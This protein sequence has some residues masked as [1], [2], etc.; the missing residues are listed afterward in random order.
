MKDMAALS[1][2]KIFQ[3]L[4][5]NI[6]EIQ[7]QNTPEI[8][9]EYVAG[10]IID[11]IQQYSSA[12]T[13]DIQPQLPAVESGS[14]GVEQYVPVENTS[15]EQYVPVESINGIEQYVPVESIQLKKPVDNTPYYKS[16][17]PS[18]GEKLKINYPL[19]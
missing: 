7:P 11:G 16:L 18:N 15:G 17:R 3:P 14:G 5:E 13:R 19:K 8:R 12:S 6:P 1:Q 4:V 9:P 10:E 2:D